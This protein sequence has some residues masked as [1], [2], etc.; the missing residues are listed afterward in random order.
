MFLLLEQ[1][2][3]E[4]AHTR[5]PAHA[6]ISLAV[7]MV[8]HRFGS[9]LAKVANGVLRGVSRGLETEYLNE[10]F[11]AQKLGPASPEALGAFYAFPARLVRLW[12]ESYGPDSS[13]ALLRAGL[14]AAPSGLRLN[15]SR[16]ECPELETALRAEQAR[17][18]P[19]AGWVLSP[20]SRLPLRR[21]QAQGLASRQSAAAYEMLSRLNPETWPQPIWDACAGRGG[22]SLALLEAGLDVR[23]ASDPNPGRLEGLRRELLRLGLDHAAGPA[24]PRLHLSPAERLNFTAVFGTVLLDAPC[25]GLGTLARRPEIRWRRAAHDLE[26]LCRLQ[27]ELLETG[28]KAL[29]KNAGNRLLYITCTLNPAENQEQIQNFLRGHAGY[30]LARELQTPADSALAEFFYAAELTWI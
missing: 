18:L 17:P 22:K 20:E 14:H 30:R 11:Y 23:E 4:L 3:Y 19:P 13:L 2:L 29:K 16:P 27:A 25:S 12:L 28:H 21:W 5:I 1:T 9:A 10:N 26:T 7:E 6:A 8:R 15:L 24:P